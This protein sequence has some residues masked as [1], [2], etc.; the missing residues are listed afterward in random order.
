MGLVTPVHFIDTQGDKCYFSVSLV[1]GALKVFG[2][3]VHRKHTEGIM[4]HQERHLDGEEVKKKVAVCS[5]VNRCAVCVIQR[6]WWEDVD[7]IWII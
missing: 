4:G 2:K 5:Q 1:T 3:E 6:S 7:L